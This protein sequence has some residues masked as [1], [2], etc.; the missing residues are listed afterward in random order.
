M[1]QYLGACLGR[2]LGGCIGALLAEIRDPE[3]MRSN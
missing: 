1:R 2:Q 3:A